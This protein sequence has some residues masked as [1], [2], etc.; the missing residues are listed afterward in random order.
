MDALRE[1]LIAKFLGPRFAGRRYLRYT[2]L[3]D[4]GI[5]GN[6]ATLKLWIDAGAFPRGIKIAGPFGR[7]LVWLVPE[8]VH[9][10]AARAA[11]RDA[12][13]ENEEGVSEQGMPSSDSDDPLAAGRNHE[14]MPWYPPPT[15]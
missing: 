10:L 1:D 3:E 4:L 12:S 11:E 2:E 15:T 6:R 13:P 9:V 7:T 8:V 14:Q 5:V